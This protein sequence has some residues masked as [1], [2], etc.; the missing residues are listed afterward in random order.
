MEFRS[1]FSSENVSEQNSEV[2]SIPKM[3]R[4]GIPR[5][6]LSENGSEWN[7]EGFYLPR[8]GLEQN[9]EVF[10]FRKTGGIPT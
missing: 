8:N 7:S 1:F 2:F 6:V 10:L 9:S 5:F 3:V 4:K